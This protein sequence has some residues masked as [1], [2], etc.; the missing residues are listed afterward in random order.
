MGILKG[1][2]GEKMASVGMW[3]F[4]DKQ[5]Y[6]RIHDLTVP[7]PNG[8]TQI[9]HVLVSSYGIF[10]VETK[11]YAGWIFGDPTQAKW[12]QVLYGKKS[13]FQN[14]LRQNYRHI[15]CLSDYLGL[16]EDRFHSI[17]FFIGESTFK[18]PMP[19]NVVN[20]RLAG[21]IGSY[22]QMILSPEEVSSTFQRLQQL[23]AEPGHTRAAHLDSLKTRHNS[24][25][26][27]P[28]C[29]APLV[30]RTARKGVNAGNQF[31]GCTQ[32]PKCRFTKA[33]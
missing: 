2:F 33:L 11:N 1:W 5:V 24:S 20:E 28:K 19:A 10:V 26:T 31:L 29:G 8:T 3:A 23:K 14:P 18:T 9:D 13:S 15:K 7:S 6:L 16:P 21:H 30:T 22:R 25:T 32:Y 4:L 12:T 17:V 27:C